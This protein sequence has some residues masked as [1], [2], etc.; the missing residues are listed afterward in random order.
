MKLLY[1]D[2]FCDIFTSIVVII[3]I[4]WLTILVFVAICVI[5]QSIIEIKKGSAK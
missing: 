2:S 4:V 1:W 3:D 5:A